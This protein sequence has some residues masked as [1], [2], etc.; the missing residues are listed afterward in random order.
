M[1]ICDKYNYNN[2][3]KV[4]EKKTDYPK[5]IKE[6]LKLYSIDKNS[7]RSRVI[8]SFSYR[9]GNAS[10]VDLF[11]QVIKPDKKILIKFFIQNLKRVAN[12]INKR[13][14]QYFLEVKLGLDHFYYDVD[15][16]ECSNDVYNVS[17]DFFQMM[18]IY[19][20]NDFLS[21]DEMDL[22]REV[23]VADKR[24][25]GH[26]EKIKEMLRKHFILRWTIDELNRGYKIL[27]DMTGEY[28]YELDL[29]IQDKSS[30]NIEGIFKTKDNKFSDCSNFFQLTYISKYG[31]QIFMNFADESMIDFLKFRQ[32]DLKKSMYTLMY[33]KIAPN[34]F[35]SAKRMMSY[36]ISFQDITLVTRCYK[37]I[38]SQYGKLYA[39]NSQLKTLAKLIKIHGDKQLDDEALY[40]HIDYI[41]WE[42]ENLILLDYNFSGV[43]N[44]LSKIIDEN[45]RFSSKEVIEIL[46]K[47]THNFMDYI[48]TKIKDVM[49]NDDL[50]PLPKYLVPEKLPF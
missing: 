49:Y 41:R 16:G 31:K 39:L 28:R 44:I 47:I 2:Y 25:Q 17:N 48:N 43:I 37:I 45:I 3:K 34:L 6:E 50:Y 23:E 27:R 40:H 8:G 11:E 15:C 32:E 20:E 22:I 4:F 38:N 29:A 12:D 10:D 46:D 18:N 9:S 14:D 19:Y 1:S 30:I 33:S 7:G 36:G 5:D 35:K 13:R 24:N 26:F 21:D 42:L